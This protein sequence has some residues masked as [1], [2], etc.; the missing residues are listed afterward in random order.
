MIRTSLPVNNCIR[1]FEEKKG[2][3]YV[4][5]VFVLNMELS[6]KEVLTAN[7]GDMYLGNMSFKLQ[8][9]GLKGVSE[10]LFS[11]IF[12]E[13]NRFRRLIHILNAI[14]LCHLFFGFGE[15]GPAI[16]QKRKN[17]AVYSLSMGCFSL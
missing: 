5:F 7:Y 12:Y 6:L 10:L 2:L 1:M 17:R 4:V 8:R 14:R 13:R 15:Y 11:R 9:L 16:L 3:T